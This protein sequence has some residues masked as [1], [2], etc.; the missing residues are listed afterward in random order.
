MAKLIDSP[1]LPELL[2]TRAGLCLLEQE[3]LTDLKQAAA[4]WIDRLEARQ[5]EYVALIE[6]LDYTIQHP[7]V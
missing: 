7:N 2:A 6:Q 5:M 4:E 3:T 1:P